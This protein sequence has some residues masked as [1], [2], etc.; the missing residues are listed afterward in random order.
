MTIVHS[1]VDF[2]AFLAPWH[3]PTSDAHFSIQHDL[4][5]VEH[6]DRLGFAEFWMG[7]HH[8][9]GVE[10]IAS[11]ELFVAAASQRTKQIKLGLG[12]VSL[13]YHHPFLLADRLV[14]LD[15]LSNGRMIFGAGPGQLADDAKMIGIDPMDNRRKMEE[16][17]AVIN[18]LLAGETVNED[19]DWYTCRDAYLHV[20]PYTDFQVAVTATVSPTGPKL[21]GRFGA[22]IL[23]L[24]A[25][26]PVGVELLAN[27]W[28]IA[29]E[30]A[31]ENGKT[32]RRDEWRLTGIMHVADTEEQARADV[33]H[34]LLELMNYLSHITP[35]FEA[36]DDLD[37]L[38][39]NINESG[40]AV[41]GT[42][43][44]AI[45]QIRRLQEKSGGFGK[46]L[47]LH[48]E[49]APT[50]AALRSFELIA[51]Q[52]AP[53]FNGDLASRKRG[54]DQTV[55]SN[56]AAADITQAGQEEAQKRFEAERTIKT[57]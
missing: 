17:F 48:G 8:S 30:I 29:E 49:W 54:F 26:N 14:L 9:G 19:T 2:G 27:H 40:L 57:H 45:N 20:A 55:N 50:H 21:A 32:V 18:R 5:L 43:E 10:I 56:R 46:F 36:S 13:P 53:H 35:G 51:Q 12:V 16:S 39:D 25:T 7:E 47:V 44:M 24:A 11:P 4:E 38:I 37:G 31:A 22:G 52:V 42:P 1:R 34:G 28:Q 3:L 15:H 33:R 23:S 41:I 6:L